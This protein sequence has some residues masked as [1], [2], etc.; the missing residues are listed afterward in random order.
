MYDDES[1][2]FMLLEQI[3]G[4]F[5]MKLRAHENDQ[6]QVFKDEVFEIRDTTHLQLYYGSKKVKNQENLSLNQLTYYP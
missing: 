5:V 6:V 4:H 3:N 2:G 1:K